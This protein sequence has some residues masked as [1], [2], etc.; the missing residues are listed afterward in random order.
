MVQW[1]V[2]VRHI[3]TAPN[4]FLTVDAVLIFSSVPAKLMDVALR[5]S[6]F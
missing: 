4:P 2:L 6:A 5:L 1:A 3:F